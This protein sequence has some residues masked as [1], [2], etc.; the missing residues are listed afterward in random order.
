[1]DG[2]SNQDARTVAL[3]RWVGDL[4]P[5][6]AD[7]LAGPASVANS[8]SLT[9]Q[10]NGGLAI[11][12]RLVTTNGATEKNWSKAKNGAGRRIKLAKMLL[13]SLALSKGLYVETF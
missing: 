7:E 3:V 6:V 10:R 2:S 5:T 1:M 13:G 9:K 11:G 12:G 4:A 8:A